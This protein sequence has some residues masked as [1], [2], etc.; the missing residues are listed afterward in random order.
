MLAYGQNMPRNNQFSVFC[1]EK[2]KYYPETKSVQ[3]FEKFTPKNKKLP[4]HRVHPYMT[5]AFLWN[6][7]ENLKLSTHVCLAQLDQHQTCKPVMVSV[8]SS[9]PTG[10]NIIFLRHLDANFVQNDRYVSFVLF[11]K[12]SNVMSQSSFSHTKRKCQYWQL[13]LYC[14]KTKKSSDKMLPWVGIEPRQLLM[15]S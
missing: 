14:M 13:C 1:P 12:T 9:N 15:S 7:A 2:V 4:S 3:I 5:V 11:T 10:S 6:H 8:V